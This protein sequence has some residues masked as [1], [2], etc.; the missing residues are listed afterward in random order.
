MWAATAFLPTQTSDSRSRRFCG[1]EITVATAEPHVY[2]A[3]M[4]L[5]RE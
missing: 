1:A 4:D 3:H 2:D 5:G